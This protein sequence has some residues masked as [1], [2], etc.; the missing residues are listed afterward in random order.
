MRITHSTNALLALA[1]SATLL[2]ACSSADSPAVSSS[3]TAAASMPSASTA[4]HNQADTMFLTMMIPHHRQAIEMADMVP[5]R[6]DNAAVRDLATRIKAA[7]QPEIDQMT[8]QLQAWGVTMPGM[9]DGHGM[10]GHGMGGAMAGMMSDDE[11]TAIRNAR[12]ATFDRL[13]L[14]GMIRHHEGAVDM[15]ETELAQGR[16]NATRDLATRIRDAQQAEIAEMQKL[17]GQ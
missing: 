10:S 13:W 5:A 9:A 4:A 17:L 11:M 15:A 1:A 7:Q 14:E 12:G 3:P 2:S 6:T 16:D 8:A